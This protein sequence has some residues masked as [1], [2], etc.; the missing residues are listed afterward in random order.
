MTS[1]M[2]LVS[3]FE[4]ISVLSTAALRSAGARSARPWCANRFVAVTMLETRPR[5]TVARSAARGNSSARY[6]SSWSTAIICMRAATASSDKA[7]F[8][9]L[10]GELLVG[11]NGSFELANTVSQEVA[12]IVHELDRGIDLVRDSSGE[13]SDRFQ[14]QRLG[15]LEL[16]PR[17][18]R[19]LLS[20]VL[21]R[22]GDLAGLRA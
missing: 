11:V 17:S 6:A 5:P 12:A 13:A 10:L 22:V 21:V 20:K 9:H 18:S 1:A 14:L 19:H 2:Y 8:A 15:E 7:S 3:F 16:D 4:M